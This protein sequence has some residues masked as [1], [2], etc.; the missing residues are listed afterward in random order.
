MKSKL[1]LI[2]ALVLTLSFVFCG[3]SSKQSAYEHIVELVDSG[4]L[5]EACQYWNEEGK[6]IFG[7]DNYENLHDYVYYSFALCDYN[8]GKPANLGEALIFL[9]KVSYDFKDTADKMYEIDNVLDGLYGKYEGVEE[10]LYGKHNELEISTN[11][12]YLGD[13]PLDVKWAV[14]DGEAI[15]GVGKLDDTEF[16]FTFIKD[17]VEVT[18]T[19]ESSY[20]VGTYLEV[21]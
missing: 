1:L 4:N 19:V 17:G 5:T 21:K 10:K 2:V 16:T 18:S 15:Y 20:Y 9:G 7:E 11:V 6:D 8:E 12:A 3:C 14:E 13:V